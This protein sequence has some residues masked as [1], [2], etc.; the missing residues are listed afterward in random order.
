VGGHGEEVRAVLPSHAAR[1]DQS[2]IGFVDER[3]GLELVVLSTNGID[4][5]R[6]PTPDERAALLAYLRKL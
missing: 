5:D 2:Q 6:P 4:F 1:I 3:R